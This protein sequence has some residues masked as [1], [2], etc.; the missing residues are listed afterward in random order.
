MS[1]LP[2]TQQCMDNGPDMTYMH[3]PSDYGWETP[4]MWPS[5]TGEM[6]QH[7]EYDI[8]AI[9]PVELCIPDYSGEEIHGSSSSTLAMAVGQSSDDYS[10]PRSNGGE[11]SDMFTG[12]FSYSE[13]AMMW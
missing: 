6:V 12:M 4:G 3:Y 7:D 8:N 13:P 10:T 9:P 1:Y 2:E 5:A 11:E